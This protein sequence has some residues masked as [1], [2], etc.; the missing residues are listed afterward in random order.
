M[1][2]AAYKDLC[3]DA[4]DR[5]VTGRFWAAALGLEL[6]DRGD[7]VAYLRGPTPAH[8]VWI[9]EVPEPK[10]VKNRMHL[11]V[12]TASVDDLRALGATVVAEFPRW[13]VM[14]DPEGGEFC[15]F[16]R[17][18]PPAYRL[19][20]V[21]LDA[22][23]HR[24]VAQWWA[25][26]LGGRYVDEGEESVWVADIPGAPFVS[27]DAG[28]VPEP[29]TGKNR[30]HLDVVG[31]TAEILARGATLLAELPRWNVLADIEGNEF[32]VFPRS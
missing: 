19:Y 25:E 10:T 14:A 6:V 9:A 23:D 30:V 7:G 20:E 16:V 1:A 26:L 21:V 32:C 8:T 27:L 18:E 22:V 13:T 11:D 2:P 12:H 28:P 15:A 4:H 5:L 29:K 24:A 31:D 3:L 17:D